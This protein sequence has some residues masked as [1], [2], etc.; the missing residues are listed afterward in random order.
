MSEKTKI[1]K[2]R[3]FLRDQDI[4]GP[5]FYF[6]SL[7]KAMDYWKEKLEPALILVYGKGEGNIFEITVDENIADQ[8]IKS[9]PE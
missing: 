1:Y 3:Y 7:Q 8:F 2:L 9:L 6:S 5:D 4:T